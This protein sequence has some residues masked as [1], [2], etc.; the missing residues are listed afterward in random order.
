MKKTSLIFV[1]VLTF[2]SVLLFP[3][4]AD[5]D[6]GPKPSVRIQFQN[7]GDELCY[8][9][10]L[11]EKES[12]GPATVWDGDENKIENLDLDLEVW[13]AFVYYKDADSYYFLQWGWQ[14]NETKELAWTYYPPQKFK[15]LLYYPES[16][17]FVVSDIYER[18]AFDSYYI[19]NMSELD[20]ESVHY[21]GELSNNERINA[22]RSYNLKLEI[23][24][25][26]ARIIIT[27]IIEMV[28]ALIFGFRGKK[29][30]LL[31]ITVNTL[32][33]IILNILLNVNFSGKDLYFVFEL[34]VVVIEAVLYCLFMNK[35]TQRKRTKTYFIT[36][37]VVANTVS[38]VA[39][40]I[41]SKLIPGAF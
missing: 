5:A 25:L 22:F 6:T 8:G 34:L 15:I 24:A 29:Q 19:V 21:N 26:I 36:Y 18:Y 9:T 14:V 1:V 41:L 39:G 23:S 40:L 32:T 27:I 31:L 20:M 2:L 35:W 7:M 10:L 33:Q 16:E 28:V 38:F 3:I 37:S 30:L 13:K 4:T 12:T 11:S 17:K